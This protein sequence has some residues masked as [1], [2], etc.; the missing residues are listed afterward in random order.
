MNWNEHVTS[1]VK[2][3]GK[4]LYMLRVLKRA[5]ADTNTLIAVYTTIIKPVLEYARQVWHVE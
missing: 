3:A 4:R 5:N 1:V 2:K